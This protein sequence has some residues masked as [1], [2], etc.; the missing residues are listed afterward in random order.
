L[1]V[2]LHLTGQR[3]SY[4]AG[5]ANRQRSE[6]MRGFDER[7]KAFEVEFKRNQEL[8]FRITARRNRLFGLWAA[9]RLGMPAGEAA[10]AY[11]KGVVL[12]DFNA[13]G[14]DDV[15]EKVRA[16]FAAKGF[17]IGEAELRAELSRAALEARTQLAQR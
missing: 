4:G 6:T 3:R 16:D 2:L 7:Q 11:A 9:A 15:I 8:A 14:E 5:T 12:A 13:P 1:F 17:E 10:E